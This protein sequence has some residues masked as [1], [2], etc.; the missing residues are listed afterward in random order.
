MIEKSPTVIYTTN[1]PQWD[2][3]MWCGC[4]HQENLGR[5][6]G[7]TESESI[8]EQWEAANGKRVE[9]NLARVA[10]LRVPDAEPGRAERLVA[11]ERKMN[12]NN[13]VRWIILAALCALAVLVWVSLCE[14]PYG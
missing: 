13:K 1:P 9:Q 2:R 4:G 5:V 7:Q 14:V 8:R 3:V 11:T 12:E 10:G 6:Y